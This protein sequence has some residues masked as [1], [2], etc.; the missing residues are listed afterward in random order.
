MGNKKRGGKTSND[1][2][3]EDNCSIFYGKPG[4]I[5]DDTLTEFTLLIWMVITLGLI[6]LVIRIHPTDKSLIH[7]LFQRISLYGTIHSKKR[8]NN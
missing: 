6:C 8:P 5:I 3:C 4:D 1:P 7:P 2:N